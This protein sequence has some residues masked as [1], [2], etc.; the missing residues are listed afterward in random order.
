MLELDCVMTTYAVDDEK[1]Q[2]GNHDSPTLH[3]YIFECMLLKGCKK[4]GIHDNIHTG[5]LI[6]RTGYSD[7]N[8]KQT[9][10]FP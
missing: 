3:H 5:K 1:R 9:L 7:E 2:C 6:H 10:C 4:P 8:S